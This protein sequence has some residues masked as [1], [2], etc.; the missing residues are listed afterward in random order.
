MARDDDVSRWFTITEN[1]NIETGELITETQI[2]SGQYYLYKKEINYEFKESIS[3]GRVNK[4][5]YRKIIKLFKETKQT[6]LF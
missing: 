1:V 4:N 2:K 5:G 6:T 3:K